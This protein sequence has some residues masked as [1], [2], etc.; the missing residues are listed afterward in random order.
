MNF[1]FIVFVIFIQIFSQI[2]CFVQHRRQSTRGCLPL[3]YQGINRL[4]SQSYKFKRIAVS[5]HDIIS[6]GSKL[7]MFQATHL[8]V[9]FQGITDRRFL[10][11]DVKTDLFM[12][13]LQHTN[14]GGMIEL[15]V[16]LFLHLIQYKNGRLVI[17][18]FPLHET[19]HRGIIEIIRGQTKP[20]NG[21]AQFED[22]IHGT[23]MT[24][25][26]RNLIVEW[27]YQ[28]QAHIFREHCQFQRFTKG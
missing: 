24:T 13:R 25:P 16:V 4:D 20:I 5:V 10:P 11:I 2:A 1:L 22:I 17:G 6:I 21:L 15:D 7:A 26:L 8:V 27:R 14:G 12:N 28:R 3:L 23:Q 9:T 18:T 19:K